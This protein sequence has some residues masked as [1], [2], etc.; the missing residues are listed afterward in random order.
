MNEQEKFTLLKKNY[1]FNGLTEEQIRQIISI[2]H[3]ISIEKI[4]A[5]L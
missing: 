2:S 5:L 4:T 1:L 3:E